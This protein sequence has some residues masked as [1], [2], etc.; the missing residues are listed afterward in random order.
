MA[1]NPSYGTTVSIGGVIAGVRSV[2]GPNMSRDPIDV[3]SLSDTHKTKIVGRPN[4]G[5][6][7]LEIL[8]D[9]TNESLAS[10][11]NATVTSTAVPTPLSCTITYPGAGGYAFSAYVTGFQPKAN[12]DEV[13]TASVTLEITGAVTMS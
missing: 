1:A 4:S 13:L 5:T 8:L 3:T 11:L 2:E 10:T 7:T 9:S 12:G 6:L